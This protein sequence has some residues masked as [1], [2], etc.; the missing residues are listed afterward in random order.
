MKD[1]GK[2][3]LILGMEITRDRKQW[4]LWLSQEKYILKLLARFN[5]E[6]SKPVSCPLGAYFKS[7]LKLRQEKKFDVEHMKHVPYALAMESLMYAMLYTRPE[8]AYTVSLLTRFLSQPGKEHWEAVKLVLRYLK[9]TSDVSV[10]FGGHEAAL[11]SFTDADMAGDLDTKRSTSGYL[12]TF[13]GERYRGNRSFKIVLLYQKLRP[14]ILRSHIVA[15]NFFG[16]RS[17]FGSLGIGKKSLPCFVIPK[18][19]YI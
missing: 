13:V 2:A 1:L 8:L 17:C 10:C 16:S 12:F 14:I 19:R 9:G 3:R 4:K 18:V 6:S 7:S 5:M 11:E 15:R